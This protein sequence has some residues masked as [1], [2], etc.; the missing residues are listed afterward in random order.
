MKDKRILGNALLVLAALIWGTAFAFQK[1][2]MDYIE[3]YTFSA[4]RL[5]LAAVA[6]ALV[7]L[8]KHEK[9]D[10]NPAEYRRNTIKGGVLCGLCLAGAA[11]FQ[12]VG[13]V[14]TT[15]GKAGFI[16]AM[17]MLLVPLA[18]FLLYRRRVTWIVWLAV[19][20]GIVGMYLLCIKDGF[21]LSKGDAL[22]SVCAFLFCFHIIFCGQYVQRGNPIAISAIQFAIAA[23]V[24]LV[25][26]VL[27]EHPSWEKI[28]SAMI[29]ILYTGLMSGGVG[30]TLQMVA[31][32]YSEPTVASI[33]MSLESVFAVLG[34]T[35][36][37]HERMSTREAIGCVVMFIAV[38]MVQ[39]PV[40]EK[41]RKV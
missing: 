27:F 4:A 39:I 7:A 8:I 9:T 24:S 12:Q 38:L 25:F 35:V 3:P 22:V 40:K 37:L 34:G 11:N 19:F 13:I 10:V 28:N 14:Y 20:V 41:N 15:A 23:F 18:S 29:P 31:Q 26:A 2:G 33:I 16:S 1:S 6:V 21:R 36:L 5:G 17:Y 30:Y 32:R